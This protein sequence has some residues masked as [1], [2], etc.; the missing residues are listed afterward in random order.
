[1]WKKS[2]ISFTAAVL[3]AAGSV[4]GASVGYSSPEASPKQLDISVGTKAIESDA[5]IDGVVHAVLG[6][7]DAV[8]NVAMPKS[9]DQSFVVTLDSASDLLGSHLPNADPA[10]DLF[11]FA[12]LV[13]EDY[14]DLLPEDFGFDKV[15]DDDTNKTGQLIVGGG[16]MA[17]MSATDLPIPKATAKAIPLPSALWMGLAT[18]PI[19]LLWRRNAARL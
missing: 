15:E 12:N 6:S 17:M 10:A 13:Y 8:T 14:I 16:G 5:T 3:F 1:M 18:L 11:D 9:T 19:A 7:N 4:Y 2:A